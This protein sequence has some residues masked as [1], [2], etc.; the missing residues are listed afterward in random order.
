MVQANQGGGGWARGD[1]GEQG[2]F[3]G[4]DDW[5]GPCESVGRGMWEGALRGAPA[6]WARV[7]GVGDTDVVNTAEPAHTPQS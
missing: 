6:L 7:L 2:A 4:R 1:E 3:D 5:R